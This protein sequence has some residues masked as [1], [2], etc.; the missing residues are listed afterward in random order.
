MILVKRYYIQ[1][2]EKDNCWSEQSPKKNRLF[3]GFFWGGGATRYTLPSSFL[4]TEEQIATAS[5]ML[6]PFENL[7]LKIVLFYYNWIILLWLNN[8]GI[9][10][11]PIKPYTRL[12]SIH[13]SMKITSRFR[14]L[15]KKVIM[16]KSVNLYYIYSTCVVGGC[17]IVSSNKGILG[18][19]HGCCSKGTIIPIEL[20]CQLNCIKQGKPGSSNAVPPKGL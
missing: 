10:L 1:Q 13:W 12:L 9:R 8:M 2:G 18:I 11:M 16:I 19:A 5:Q 7:L 15:C 14:S 17:I 6:P 3:L 4:L 20:H